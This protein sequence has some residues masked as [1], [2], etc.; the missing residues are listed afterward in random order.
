[1][2]FLKEIGLYRTMKEMEVD[3]E[4]FEEMLQSPVLDVLPF[5]NRD[6]LET[7]LRESYE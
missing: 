3:R 7:I 2:S 1:M 4:A 5:G 6:E